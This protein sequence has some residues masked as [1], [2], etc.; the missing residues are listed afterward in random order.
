MTMIDRRYNLSYTADMKTAISIPDELFAVA[1][2][3]ARRLGFSRSELYQRAIARYLEEQSGSTIT[4]DLDAIYEVDDNR[5]L[6][7][8][9]DSLQGASIAREDW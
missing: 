9:L 5:G 6:D 2:R 8:V 7:P 3:L 4:R 1:D